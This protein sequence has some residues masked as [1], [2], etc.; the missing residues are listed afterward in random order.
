MTQNLVFLLCGAGLVLTLA[1]VL[2]DRLNFPQRR[3]RPKSIEVDGNHA[4]RD[5][6]GAHVNNIRVVKPAQSEESP[7]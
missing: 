1:A 7:E 3:F 2:I 4:S 6:T 5:R